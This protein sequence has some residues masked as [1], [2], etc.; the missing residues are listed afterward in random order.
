MNETIDFN[1]NWIEN[2]VMLGFE[3]EVILDQDDFT[4]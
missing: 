4:Y 3:S 2:R 1:D